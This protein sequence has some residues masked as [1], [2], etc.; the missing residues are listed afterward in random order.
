MNSHY[1]LIERE[2]FYRA[3]TADTSQICD[4][5]EL[6]KLKSSLDCQGVRPVA[7]PLNASLHKVQ[8]GQ[9]VQ[10]RLQ[11]GYKPMSRSSSSPSRCS[12]SSRNPQPQGPIKNKGRVISPPKLRKSKRNADLRPDDLNVSLRRGQPSHRPPRR[13]SLQTCTSPYISEP[14]RSKSITDGIDTSLNSSKSSSSNI[15]VRRKSEPHHRNVEYNE[16]LC[17]IMKQPKYSTGYGRNVNDVD[18]SASLPPVTNTGDF[19]R[20]LDISNH[21]FNLGLSS[22]FPPQEREGV[23]F[24]PLKRL[25][26]EES[27]PPNSSI[28]S[29]SEDEDWLPKGVEFCTSMEVY[30][31][32]PR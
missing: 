6:E 3:V 24:A 18:L 8:N 22:S 20:L 15:K 13:H 2:A 16:Q 27:T 26:E 11:T 23:G 31:F 19:S 21:R 1:P 28:T 12:R 10:D 30:V 32:K 4:G 29:I 14:R 9:G 17:G 5:R 7:D 25:Q